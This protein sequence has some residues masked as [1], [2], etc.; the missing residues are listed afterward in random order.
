MRCASS[1]A[2]WSC[3]S[4]CRSLSSLEI[5][6]LVMAF[7]SIGTDQVGANRGNSTPVGTLPRAPR[8]STRSRGLQPICMIFMV[9]SALV[10]ELY[11]GGGNVVRAVLEAETGRAVLNLDD[12]V[13]T[14]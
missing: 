2:L 10:L 7:Q 9:S 11:A 8:N 13:R 12:C 6:V 1:S 5:S 14:G 4:A 3:S